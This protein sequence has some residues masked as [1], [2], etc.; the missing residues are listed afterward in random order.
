[1]TN[2]EK[3]YD[4]IKKL[5]E[6]KI[7]FAFN[8]DGKVVRCTEC[9]CENCIFSSGGWVCNKERLKWLY[10]EAE[11]TKKDVLE[12]IYNAYLVMCNQQYCDNCAYQREQ[13]KSSCEMAFMYEYLNKEEN[14]NERTLHCSFQ[15]TV[16]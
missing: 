1:M 16:D 4:E 2:F 7:N 5:V 14:K 8:K 10:E 11:K 13:L 9:P 3:Y 12:E 6:E 15:G